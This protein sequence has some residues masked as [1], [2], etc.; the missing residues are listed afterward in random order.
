MFNVFRADEYFQD[1]CIRWSGPWIWLVWLGW[2]IVCDVK[3]SLVTT[4][5][6]KSC[7]HG[8]RWWYLVVT[9]VLLSFP[10]GCLEWDMGLTCVSSWHVLCNVFVSNGLLSISISTNWLECRWDAVKINKINNYWSSVADYMSRFMLKSYSSY[11][12]A[13]YPPLIPSTPC[14]TLYGKEFSWLTYSAFCSWLFKEWK[15]NTT[16]GK[17]LWLIK[18]SIKYVSEIK[19]NVVSRTPRFFR[20]N[21]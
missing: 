7:S 17:V 19:D 14:Q 15:K 12:S 20:F 8:C 4:Y 1:W 11:H 3:A 2:Y 13:L 9:N 10:T 6:G 16:I 5:V 18:F 21:P